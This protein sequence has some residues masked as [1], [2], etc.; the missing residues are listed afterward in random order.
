MCRA[1]CKIEFRHQIIL[2]NHNNLRE[3]KGVNRESIY[4]NVRDIFRDVFDDYNLLIDDSTNADDV[5]EWDSLNHIS[6]VLSIEKRFKI[7]FRTNEV[8]TLKDVGE[9]ID[10][11]EQKLSSF[12]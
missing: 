3:D 10:L 6:L 2:S 12:P 7:R 8:Q 9:M 1:L 4:E 5:E 11:L